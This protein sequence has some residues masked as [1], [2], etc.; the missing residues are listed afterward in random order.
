MAYAEHFG[1]VGR[2][3]KKCLGSGQRRPCCEFLGGISQVPC[4]FLWLCP[5]LLILLLQIR[6]SILDQRQQIR[7]DLW[8]Q[9][10]FLLFSLAPSS[11]SQQPRGVQQIRYSRLEYMQQINSDRQKH[12]E[13]CFVVGR[14]TGK[15]TFYY[16]FK[17][18]ADFMRTHML[19]HEY[20][21]EDTY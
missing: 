17:T 18:H 6:F 15:H 19:E 14:Q 2:G 9:S 11:P 12:I 16:F 3:K 20:T 21:Y 4:C 7:L 10:I 13:I 5:L 8:Y 1:R